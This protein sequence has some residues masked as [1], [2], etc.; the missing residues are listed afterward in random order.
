MTER[1][2]TLNYFY[3]GLAMSFIPIHSNKQIIL[4]IF[5]EVNLMY[6]WICYMQL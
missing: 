3:L 5:S 4:A 1:E 2:C 6:S